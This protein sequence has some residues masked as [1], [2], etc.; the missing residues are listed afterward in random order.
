MI[1]I[2][3][4]FVFILLPLIASAQNEIDNEPKLAL[5]HNSNLVE[6]LAQV[7]PMSINPYTSVFATSV[8]SKFGYHND[9]VSTHPFYNNWIV[10]VL[11]GIL[12]FFTLIVRPAMATNQLTGTLVKAD[13]WLENKAGLIINGIV[14]VLPTFF[15]SSPIGDDVVI[16]AGFL[17]LSFNTV[18]ILVASTYLLFVIM[19]VRLFIDFLIFLSPVPLIDTALQLSKVVLSII[20]C[21]ISILSPITALVITLLMFGVSLLF[22]KQA[23]KLI[24]RI[25]YFIVY[26]ILNSFRSK[27]K[28]LTDGEGLSILVLTKTK[29][30]NFKQNKIVRLE[31]KG[32]KYNIAKSRFP[33]PKKI[34]E[35]H[36]ES[37]SLSQT[38][39][40][41]TLRANPNIELAL[42]RS[43]HKFVDELS[44]E[45]HAKIIKRAE[46]KL[47]MNNG[48]ISKVK[49]M[50]AQSDL[51]KLRTT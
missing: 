7:A 6:Q 20:L 42:N 37:P 44:D 31:K 26:P 50:F 12:F 10:L 23:T 27:E 45:L 13:N 40:D 35:L 19:T 51:I 5:Q 14:V 49:G 21:V 41:T 17:S 28:I 32:S 4:L 25:V 3:L 46:L 1:K 33:F 36:L 34:E 30:A 24:N 38:H 22:L 29:T 8:F 11:S 2:K 9:Y 15:S 43:Y 16:E 47:D 39:I 48:I 18:L